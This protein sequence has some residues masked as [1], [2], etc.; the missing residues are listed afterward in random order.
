MIELDDIKI[1]AEN[2]VFWEASSE[3]VFVDRPDMADVAIIEVNS[4]KESNATEKFAAFVR[5]CC[6][7]RV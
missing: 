7:P 2:I 6:L 5:G 4:F 3:A 1:P